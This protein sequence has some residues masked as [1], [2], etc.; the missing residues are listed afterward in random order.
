[1]VTQIKESLLYIV[2]FIFIFF[3]GFSDADQN[4]RYTDIQSH[5]EQVKTN[6]QPSPRTHV[7]KVMLR[8]DTKTIPDQN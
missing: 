3:A 1:M 7:A 8:Q 4:D 6:S 2:L 5:S